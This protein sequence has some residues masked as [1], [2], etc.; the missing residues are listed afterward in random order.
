MLLHNYNDVA[1]SIQY[2]DTSDS[3]ERYCQNLNNFEQK[4]ILEKYNFIDSTI[5]YR[6]N[7]DGFRGDEISNQECL[8][9][10]C[11]FTMG[12]G[13]EE[14]HTWPAKLSNLLS[15]S[16]A[17]LGHAGSSNDSALRF[18][19][20]YI[21]KIKPK[22]AIWVQ[23]DQYRLEIINEQQNIVDNIIVNLID[24]LP[25]RN[26]HFI[27]HWTLCE[28]N[29]QLNLVKNTLAFRQLC[30][31]HNTRCVILPRDSVVSID[32][33]RDL[34]HPGRLSNTKLAERISR[35]I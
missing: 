16:V 13:I 7:R 8:C 31:E 32:L 10:G 15:I 6:F 18:A 23:T 2:W 28:T 33:A 35:L 24:D 12:T 22:L 29:Q 4:K 21:P 26:D 17:N 11:S 19:L 5:E 30:Q 14:E 9:F 27:K 34:M 25:Y 20:H 3:F 1:G